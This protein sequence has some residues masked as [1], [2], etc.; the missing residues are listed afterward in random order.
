MLPPEQLAAAQFNTYREK[1]R[2]IW[3]SKQPLAE[4][5]VQLRQIIPPTLQEAISVSLNIS[6]V[7][8][9]DGSTVIQWQHDLLNLSMKNLAGDI[10]KMWFAY[11]HTFD[12]LS[13]LPLM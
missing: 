3:L 5:V 13:L 12:D 1:F 6:V 2:D 11:P 4:K 8:D 9:G 7:A 10:L